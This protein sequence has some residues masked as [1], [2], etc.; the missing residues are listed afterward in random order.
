MNVCSIRHNNFT[1]INRKSHTPHARA[2]RGTRAA[3]FTPRRAHP[4]HH[5]TTRLAVRAGEG[6]AV[7]APERA[8]AARVDVGGGARTYSPGRRCTGT[9][10]APALS[11]RPRRR[12]RRHAL[13]D[14]GGGASQQRR[15]AARPRAHREARAT[16]LRLHVAVVEGA[17][18]RRTA[19]ARG[20]SCGAVGV[21]VVR[22]AS[23]RTG[24]GPLRVVDV[25]GVDGGRC[26]RPSCRG[27]S[28]Q[29]G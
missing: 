4:L 1:V 27:A 28:P 29:R 19:V 3:Q 7:V 8:H 26:G 6:S 2:R 17:P 18:V 12:R 20:V 16:Q 14:L 25:G 13:A 11:R 15:H 24:D 10:A 21:R 5:P 9:S 22:D 23:H